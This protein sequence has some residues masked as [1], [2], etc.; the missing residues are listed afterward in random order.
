MSR[1][2]FIAAATI[3]LSIFSSIAFSQL[4]T[5]DGIPADVL[6]QDSLISGCVTAHNI[7]T[8]SSDAFGAFSYSGDDFPFSSGL[9]MCS[10]PIE[11]AIGPDDDT[12]DG[13]SIGSGSDEDLDALLSSSWTSIYDATIIEFDF[14]P[15]SDTIRFNY[16]FGSEEFPEFANSSFND[17]FGFFLSGPGINGPYSNNAINIAILP[18]GDPVTIDNVYNSGTWYLGPTGGN[19]GTGDAY[20]NVVQYDGCTVEL[21]AEAIVTACETYHIKLAVGDAGD[22][23]Y[24]TGVFIEAGSFTSGVMI[25]TVSHSDVGTDADLYEGCTNYFVIE[26]AENSPIDE[27]VVIYINYL[28]ES[29]ATQN[30]DVSEIPDSVYMAPFEMQD[31]IWYSAFN[32]GIE[33]GTE[34][35]LLE[36]WTACPCGNGGGNSVVD[37]I[38]VYDVESIKGGIQDVETNYCGTTPPP[39]LDIVAEVDITPAFYEW[40]TGSLNDTITIVPQPG[41]ETYFVTITDQCGNEI[42]DSVTIRVSSMSLEGITPTHVSC[43][44]TCDGELQINAQNDYQPFTYTYGNAS[45]FY[46]PDSLTHTQNPHI[47]GLCPKNYYIKVTD[48]IGCYIETLVQINNKPNIQLSDGILPIETE[49]C[50]NPGEITL[51]AS[52][53]VDDAI[54]TWFNDT[55][56]NTVSFTPETGENN[57]SV[58]ITDNCDNEF[59]DE[60]IILVSEIAVNSTSEADINGN[61]NG[62][63]MAEASQGIPPYSYYWQSPL[64]AQGQHQEDVCQGE[65]T[66]VAT[67]DIGCTATSSVEVPFVVGNNPNSV[68]NISVYPN[69]NYGTVIINL[70]ETDLSST[71]IKL[72]DIT[73]KLIAIYHPKEK[74]F[75]LTELSVGTYFIEIL[76]NSIP[77]FNQRMLVVE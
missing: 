52:A 56:T 46:I 45:Y 25:N 62:E 17:V 66:V 19:G 42:Y 55:H 24:D 77:V 1:F 33:E 21:T 29:T 26:R 53:N 70:G 34:T 65:Y 22:S 30:V 5:Q 36:F 57:Y 20:N 69:P 3:A 40:S 11:N 10:G 2:I 4:D 43:Y 14:V 31:T 39:T 9:I 75:E 58:T 6:I 7:T 12:N 15:A 49:Y 27:E 72:T 54:F 64:S 37:T 16:I 60:I 59:I 13:G 23:A 44:N 18:N 50:G 28:S 63:V 73:G 51:T 8:N 38:Y 71:E 47:T 32:D 61:C 68:N 35:M 76:E 74:H 48:T 67:D 41:T